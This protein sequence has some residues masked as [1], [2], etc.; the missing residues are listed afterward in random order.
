MIVLPSDRV[1][2]NRI[3]VA[4]A[5]AAIY[6]ARKT[7]G[8]KPIVGLITAAC[9]PHPH[10]EDSGVRGARLFRIYIYYEVLRRTDR[11]QRIHDI[12]KILLVS[13]ISTNDGIHL[14]DIAK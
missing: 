11:L 5:F 9:W 14:Q 4:I 2:S 13:H 6:W 10:T 7:W 8:W 3:V 12:A 1:A